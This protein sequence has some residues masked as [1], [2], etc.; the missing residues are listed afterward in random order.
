AYNV[1]ASL[2]AAVTVNIPPA[3]ALDLSFS[4]NGPNSE[5]KQVLVETNTGN[6]YICGTFSQ[7]DGKVRTYVARMSSAGIMDTN[8]AAPTPDGIV[9]TIAL[10]PDGKLVMGGFFSTVGGVNRRGIA[11]LN[12]NGSLDLAFSNTL[13]LN[14]YVYALAILTN[15][16]IL[17]GGQFSTI[18]SLT[19]SNLVRLNNDGTPDAAWGSPNQA[20]AAVQ[21]LALQP[22]K[23]ILIGGSFTNVLGTAR[24][25]VARLN[26]DGTLDATFDVGTGPTANTSI[27]TIKSLA[28]GGVLVGG[29]FTTFNAVVRSYLVRLTSTG[30]VD[31]NFNANLSATVINDVYEQADGKLLVGGTV[32]QFYNSL[33]ANGILRFSANGLI[34]TNFVVGS[35]INAGS[36][37]DSIALQPDGRILIGGTFTSVNGVVKFYLARLFGNTAPAISVAITPAAVTAALGDTV[38]YTAAASGP[39]TLR[40]QWQKDGAALAGQT[41]AFLQ[42]FNVQTNAAGNYA[43]VVSNSATV[44]TS[45]LASLSF[46]LGN[47]FAT[48]AATNG[49]APGNNGLNQDPDNDGIPNIFEYYFGTSPLGADVNRLPQFIPVTASGQSY[50]GVTFIRSKNAPGVSGTV[51]IGTDLTF[52]T[53][54]SSTVDSVVDLGNGTE[55]VTIRSTVPTASLPMQFLVLQLTPN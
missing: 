17:V 5:V 49:L 45:A 21:A 53:L 43:V 24:R 18:N 16:Q 38:F 10:Q 30:A 41:N 25:Q 4:T 51:V 50:P 36:T 13:N 3:G 11:R 39:A 6:L 1:V 35:G 27:A 28:S 23:K 47:T 31:T 34:D 40:F 29:N 42:L 37:V 19:R 12:S 44:V 7:V 14:G 32:S 9:Q 46:N 54:L 20:V 8:F 33:T 15:S 22:D 48:W 2:P 52:A 55:A 26:E